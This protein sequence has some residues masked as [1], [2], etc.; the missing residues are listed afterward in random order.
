MHTYKANVEHEDVN[1]YLGSVNNFLFD[2]ITGRRRYLPV[3][4]EIDFILAGSPCQGF[5]NANPKGHEALKS[6]SNSALICTTLSAIDFYRP[7]YAI[8]ENVPAMASDR[9]YRGQDV[10][11]SN[12]IMCALIGMGYQCRCLLLDAWHFGAPQSRTRL[13]IEIAAPGCALPEIPPGSHAHHPDVRSRAVGKTAADIKFAERDLDILTAFPPVKL[14]DCWNDL[15]SIGNGQLGVCISHP[16]HRLYRV[17]NS[18]DRN[19]M[20]H[21]P[22]SAPDLSG[23]SRNPGYKYSLQRGLIPPHLQLRALPLETQDMRFTRLSADGLCPTVTC[24]ITPISHVGG[25]V[26]HY[27]ENRMI[28]NMEAKRAQGFLDTD[29]L[30]GTSAKAF[31]IVGNSVCRQVAFALGGKLA[32]AVRKGPVGSGTGSVV[33]GVPIPEDLS[34]QPRSALRPSVMVLIEER[35]RNSSLAAWRQASGSVSSSLN[36][37]VPSEDV[38]VDFKVR[39][40]GDRV[41]VSITTSPRKRIRIEVEEDEP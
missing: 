5:S 13:F 22:Q 16:D 35:S 7:K 8:L 19:I 14:Q 15:P 10:N 26:M 3:R 9:K 2:V 34:V 39:N 4:G 25:K 31:R 30:V 18:R 37:D 33:E 38:R 21:I 24:V 11:I 17:A 12:Q 23:S 1:L 32:E 40:G 36:S 28:S 27:K 6:L 20:A 29:V 41:E